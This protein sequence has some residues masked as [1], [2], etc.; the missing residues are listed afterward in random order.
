MYST[1]K[2]WKFPSFL[3]FYISEIRSQ[4]KSKYLYCHCAVQHYEQSSGN[5]AD[6]MQPVGIKGLPSKADIMPSDYWR[7]PPQF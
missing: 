7:I 3:Q 2:F 1:L 5:R 4:M 6:A